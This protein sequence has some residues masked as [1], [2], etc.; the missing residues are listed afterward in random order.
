MVGVAMKV[1]ILLMW[2][3]VVAGRGILKSQW[4]GGFFPEGASRAD[5]F[6]SSSGHHSSAYTRDRW[7]GVPPATGAPAA[8]RGTG[9]GNYLRAHQS[10]S[11]RSTCCPLFERLFHW[12]A[13]SS[14]RCPR[15][16]RSAGMA[17]AIASLTIVSTLIAFMSVSCL[18]LVKRRRCGSNGKSPT[19]CWRFGRFGQVRQM[20]AYTCGSRESLHSSCELPRGRN[21]RYLGSNHAVGARAFPLRQMAKRNC[22]SSDAPRRPAS[23]VLRTSNPRRRNPTRTP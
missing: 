19:A 18:S 13:M 23:T 22:S 2:H 20:R 12:R 16:G 15:S 3:P 9:R 1:S 6:S 14:T 5:G 21:V 7:R 11:V 8:G 17:R 4:R 10:V